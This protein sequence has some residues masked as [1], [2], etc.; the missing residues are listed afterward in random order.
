MRTRAMTLVFLFC[1]LLFGPLLS[2]VAEGAQKPT[3]GDAAVPREA[4]STE[5][6]RRILSLLR[7]M[8]NAAIMY[9]ADE[10]GSILDDPERFRERVN[11]DPL[12]VRNILGRYLDAPESFDETCHFYVL[13][14]GQGLVGCDLT[15]ED[16]ATLET[17]DRMAKR[18]GADLIILDRSAWNGGLAIC[19]KFNMKI[20]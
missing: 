20:W 5:R 14:D 11:R 4:R 6:A 12:A 9:C 13:E 2:H 3:A 16:D 17:L 7:D 19:M 1:F 15:D 10:T 8:K 18:S